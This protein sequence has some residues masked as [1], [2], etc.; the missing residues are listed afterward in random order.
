MACGLEG[1]RLFVD[2][3]GAEFPAVK[4][5]TLVAC[6][7]L[8]EK[9]GARR[10]QLDGYGHGDEYEGRHYQEGSREKYVERAFDKC[11]DGIV[12]RIVS[13][14]QHRHGSDVLRTQIASE[15]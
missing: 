4:V 6:A 13:H 5:A 11:I 9:H 15:I 14:A 8:A 3:H 7:Q 2:P 10:R 1:V 12:E